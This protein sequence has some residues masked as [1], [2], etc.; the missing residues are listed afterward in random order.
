MARDVES[1]V[2]QMSADVRR[3]E[4]SMS[5]MRQVADKRL[6][7]VEKRATQADRRLSKI[8][9]GA[10]DNMV[11]SFKQNLGALAPTLAAAFSVQQVVRYA[12]SYT[13]LQ[14]QLRS[15]GLAGADL[16]RVEDALYETAN[17]NGVAI[18]ATAQL[19]TRAALSRKSLG[20]SEAELLALVSGTTAALRVQGVSAEAA[21][22]PLLQLGQALGG[23]K[24]QAE[25]FNSLIDGL[26]VLLQAAANGSDKFGGDIGKLR[27]A[28]KSGEV[29]SKEFF[30]ALLKGFPE[31]EKQ[32]A[33]STQTVGQALQNLNNQLGR[34]VGETDSGLSATQR[35]AQ[36]I[37]A[38]ANNLDVLM[39]ILG[40]LIAAF[41]V[42]YVLALTQATGALIANGVASVRLA[43]FQT[44]MTASLTGTTAATV[45]ATSATR[46]FTAA[47]AA[48]PIGA[49]LVVVAALAGGLYFLIQRYG[50][51]AVAA[52]ELNAAVSAADTQIATYAAAVLKAR[53]ASGENR[54]ALLREAEAQRVLTAARIADLK[55]VAQQ[56][57]DEAVASRARADEAIGA[58]NSR[59]EGSGNRSFS[60]A[61]IIQD[62]AAAQTARTGISQAQQDRREA[63]EALRAVRNAEAAQEAAANPVRPSG[64]VVTPTGGKDGGAGPSP[65]DLAAQRTLLTLQGEVETLR[66]QG[67]ASEAD[68]RQ[69]QID[70]LQLTERYEAAGFEDAK[71]RAE[72]HVEA[73]ATARQ[74]AKAREDAKELAEGEARAVEMMRGFAL[75][76]LGIQEEL[77]LTDRDALAVRREI[78]RIRQEERR[79]AL[80]AAAADKDATEAERQA[81]RSTLGQLPAL[82]GGEN[83]A[84]EGSSEGA[85]DAR[86]IVA[87]LNPYADA[88]ERAAEAYAE[89][90]RLR[91]EDL[92]SEQE[93]ALA[94]GQIDADLRDARLAGTRGMLDTL[95]TLQNSSNKKLAAL[96][97]AAAIA[98]ATIDGVL[99]VQKA[100]ASAPPPFNFIQAAIVGAVAAA[101]VANIAGMADGGLVTGVGGPRQ[102]NQLRWLSS[103][104]F[105]NNAAS[106]R[107]NR[108]F[109]EAANDG[110]DLGKLLPRMADGGLVGRVNAASAGL[111]SAGRGVPSLT[112]APVIDARGADLAAVARLEQ[113]MDD[114]R[115]RFADNVN[116][117]RDKRAR[118]RIGGRKT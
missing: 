17:R 36:G 99:A 33:S 113:V 10:G 76:M 6:S 32:A 116:A 30:A 106:V 91:Q 95:A 3:F 97:K 46:A 14:N 81:A 29:T 59:R 39:P 24:I 104:E 101:N 80:E 107:K 2:L 115:R 100:L 71:A 102:D 60:N 26:P 117:V 44:A 85:R 110:A 62:Q 70:T 11:R 58:S 77:A 112:Y 89:I 84:L 51:S 15:T 37:N 50:S 57:I 12:D 52:R 1:L 48:N 43:A 96:G 8:M 82:E 42:R 55:V 68:A 72:Q 78:L 22:G 13:N 93:A 64:G 38:L 7:E 75:D 69:D 83:R 21:S 66:A 31:L 105:V 74:E 41:G 19:Y 5:S 94:K 40:V 87:D 53:D 103:G 73:L 49:A 65:E 54:A 90:D 79:A 86:A 45:G 4:K 63:D 23:G 35:M 18:D 109:L 34:F 111:A 114:Q 20:A 118:Y 16:K 27:A 28:V 9:G 98:Q 61:S 108:P 92:I 88:V 67:R 25:E 47:I 56:R